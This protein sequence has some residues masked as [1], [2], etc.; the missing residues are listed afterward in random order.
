VL[1]TPRLLL[2]H[3]RPADSAPLAALFADPQ[4][5]RY[6]NGLRDAAFS[7]SWLARVQD[8]FARR[9]FGIWAV[10]RRGHDDFIGF[11]GL[12]EIPPDMPARPGVEIV[13]T[14]AA[15][16]W[17][18]GYAAEAAAACLTDGFARCALPGI[19][20]FTA[21]INAPSRAV[22]RRIGLLHDAAA[23]F[24]HPRIPA[25]N[26]LCGHVLY[27]AHAPAAPRAT[28]APRNSH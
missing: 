27:R 2:R 9:G 15:A 26:P 14:L 25:E 21:A 19:I 7:A 13:W 22:M 3:W 18:Q 11:V 1:T 16:H 28:I 8:H 10:G 24:A 20:A 12:S 23:D 5:M 6:F 17:R 4:V